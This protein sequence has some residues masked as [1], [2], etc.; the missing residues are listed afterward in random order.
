MDNR[1]QVSVEVIL[2]LAAVVAVVLLLVSQLQATGTEA[3]EKVG[4]TSENVFEKVDEII[5]SQK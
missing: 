4:K 2:V 5:D 3:A 1:A